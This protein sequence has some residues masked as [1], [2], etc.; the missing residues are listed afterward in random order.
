M[1]QFDGYFQLGL[2]G[3]ISAGLVVMALTLFCMGWADVKRGGK[4]M[5]WLWFP[6]SGVF[7]GISG[8]TIPYMFEAIASADQLRSV[9]SADYVWGREMWA[10]S[11]L[12][13]LRWFWIYFNRGLLLVGLILS[14]SAL[15][16]SYYLYAIHTAHG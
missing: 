8:V 9:I 5:P 14:A 4:A 13:I 2:Q 15:W 12:F 1:I 3:W 16:T 6:F 7:V 11:Q 10:V